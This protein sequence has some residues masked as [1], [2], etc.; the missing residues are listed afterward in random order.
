M[1]A[2]VAALRQ[3]TNDRSKIP[4]RQ[5]FFTRSNRGSRG[6]FVTSFGG[7]R[8]H[9]SW[10]FVR[11]PSVNLENDVDLLAFHAGQQDVVRRIYVEHGPALLRQVRRYTGPAEAEAVVHD[12]FV[13]L[14]KNHQLRLQYKG[15]QL[16]AW[17]RQIGRLKALEHLRRT[18]RQIPQDLPEVGISDEGD[19]EAR[20]LLA[21]FLAVVPTAQRQFF[22]L[23]FLER[24]TQVEIAASLGV[25]RSTLEGWEHQLVKKLRAF[26]LEGA[27]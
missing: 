13:E 1:T 26:V 25:P 6:V 14:L 9:H 18:G 21:R 4:E 22:G 5:V 10:G 27:K 7:Q 11:L 23:R 19:V 15:G 16:V 17:L 8:A 12:L 24:R 3:A 20:D 2:F